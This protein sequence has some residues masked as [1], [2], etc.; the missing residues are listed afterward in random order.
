MGFGTACSTE[1]VP[2]VDREAPKLSFEPEGTAD[3]VTPVVRLNVAGFAD[4]ASLRL[5]RD[6]LSEYH[7]GRV[8]AEDLPKTLLEREVPAVAFL[9][10]GR[11]RCAPSEVL[12]AGVYSLASADVGLIGS[13]AVQSSAAPPV[14]TRL[15]PPRGSAASVAIYCGERALPAAVDVA[16]EPAAISGRITP[17]ASTDGLFAERCLRLEAKEPLPP[18]ALALPPPLVGDVLLEPSPLF[19]AEP[20]QALAPA[21]TEIEVELGAACAKVGDDRLELRANQPLLVLFR[22]PSP[23]LVLLETPSQGQVIQG[24]PPASE[25]ALSGESIDAAGRVETFR[26]SVTTAAAVPRVVINEVLANPAGS[27]PA[28]EWIELVND[29]SRSV[30]LGGYALS[31]GGGSVTLPSLSLAP[32]QFVVLVSAEY[33]AD[34]GL[35]VV[36][37]DSSVLLPLPELAKNGLSNSGELL[38]LFDGEG[39]LIS[40]FPALKSNAAGVSLARRSP[41]SGDDDASAFGP[42][43]P[44]GASPGSNNTLAE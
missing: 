40:R 25:L 13:F 15:W 24:L 30:D 20:G 32:G 42:H 41:D 12:A 6:E 17:G 5:F 8:R 21:C 22:E 18:G 7:L 28:Q 23:A 3:A 33:V 44:P 10:D 9:T 38:R 4:P 35:D 36:A 11:A 16:L 27:E 39:T 37:L 29:G 34:P 14:L 1:L 2:P 19:G 43:A 26:V 31:D